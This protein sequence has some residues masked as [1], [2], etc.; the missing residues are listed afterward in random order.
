VYHA[1]LVVDAQWTHHR[2]AKIGCPK[3]DT[4]SDEDNHEELEDT[5]NLSLEL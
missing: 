3:L 5:L 2:K 4:E 1:I